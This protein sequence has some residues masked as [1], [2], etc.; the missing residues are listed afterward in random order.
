[1]KG[2]FWNISMKASE[3]S[4]WEQYRQQTKKD[5]GKPLSRAEFGRKCFE[6]WEMFH[7]GNPILDK[8]VEQLENDV[9]KLQDELDE[10]KS[11]LD[12]LTFFKSS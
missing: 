9:Q 6:F 11:T 10:K 7:S 8:I 5:N 3:E 4:K 12:S 2:I 1:M